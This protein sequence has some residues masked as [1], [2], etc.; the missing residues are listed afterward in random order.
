MEEIEV[1][2]EKLQED[3]MEHAEHAGHS[4]HASWIGKVALS[5]AL[6]AVCAAVSALMAGHHANEAMIDQIRSSDEWNFYQAKGIKAAVL[7]SKT[8]LLAELGKP[9]SEKDSEKQAEYKKQQEEISERAHEKE[10]ASVE[11]LRKHVILARAVTL[12]QVAIG[13]AAISV[14]TR[15]RRFWFVGLAFG[16]L[17]VVFL[18]QGIFA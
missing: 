7:A 18:V 9:A 14:L 3:I 16:G 11:H 4:P 5:S 6:L 10:A 15:R 17:G 8:E 1:P 13:V 12:F 2:V